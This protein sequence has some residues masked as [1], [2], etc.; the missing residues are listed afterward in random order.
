M[1][2]KREDIT[3]WGWTGVVERFIG[4]AWCVEERS[5]LRWDCGGDDRNGRTRRRGDEPARGAR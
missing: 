4:D 1:K 3:E 5:R 2:R